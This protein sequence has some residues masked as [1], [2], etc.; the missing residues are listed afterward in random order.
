MTRTLSKNLTSD[1]TQISVSSQASER[2]LRCS[3]K[4]KRSSVETVIFTKYCM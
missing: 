3:I 4:I 2:D 1:A